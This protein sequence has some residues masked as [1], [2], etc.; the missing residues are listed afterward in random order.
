MRPSPIAGID[1]NQM[2]GTTVFTV[3]RALARRMPM[4]RPVAFLDETLATQIAL[5]WFVPCEVRRRA[6]MTAH[7]HR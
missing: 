1:S 5:A 4:A 7:A 2:P 6:K 3:I